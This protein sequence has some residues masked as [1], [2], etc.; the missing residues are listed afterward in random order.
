M[1]ASSS[2]VKTFNALIEKIKAENDIFN[3][4]LSDVSIYQYV[5]QYVDAL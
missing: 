2:F 1:S 5:G 3:Q 4:Q